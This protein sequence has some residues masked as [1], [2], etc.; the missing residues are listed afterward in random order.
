MRTKIVITAMVAAIVG[1]AAGIG[2]E[3]F[4]Q[5]PTSGSEK[6]HSAATTSP[7]NI[8]ARRDLAALQSANDSLRA[9]NV[10]LRQRLAEAGSAVANNMAAP[11]LAEENP[12]DAQAAPV[13]PPQQTA[14]QRR[15]AYEERMERL[16][17]ENPEEYQRIQERRAM[18]R[19]RTAQRAQ[20]R[21]EF[22]EAIDTRNMTR[23]QRENHD[24]LLETA[25]HLSSLVT[26]MGNPG[27]ERTPELGREIRE[28]VRQAESLYREE[29][30]YLLEEAARSVGYKGKDATAF[31]E[32][33]EGVILN[34]TLA[35]DVRRFMGGNRRPGQ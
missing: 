28:S 16:R 31:A 34:T 6:N 35:P 20:D 10:E 4:I 9:A 11:T 17:T 29:R 8:I 1:I 15:A 5:K 14:E 21:I 25:D 24:K 12:P 27:V 33:I 13:R 26:Q 22:L 2:V 19:E 3:R 32:H 30:R 7:D 23:E 18:F